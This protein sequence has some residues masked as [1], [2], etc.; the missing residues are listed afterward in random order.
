MIRNA[1]NYAQFNTDN[2][3][4]IGNVDYEIGSI[5]YK[6]LRGSLPNEEEFV[7]DLKT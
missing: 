6:N 1:L 5:Y 7:Q 4:I 3:L 2:D